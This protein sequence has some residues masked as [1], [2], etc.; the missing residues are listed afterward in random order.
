VFNREKKNHNHSVYYLLPG[1]S[2]GAR[3][4]ARRNMFLGIG[5]G[6]FLSGLMWL[7]FYL[8]SRP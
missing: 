6:L 3:R 8:L 5:V 4:R 2:R 1:M 7:V